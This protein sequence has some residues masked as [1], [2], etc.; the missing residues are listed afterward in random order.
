MA[1]FAGYSFDQRPRL[2]TEEDLE[3][4]STED[5]QVTE[6]TND[7]RTDLDGLLM[8]LEQLE[9]SNFKPNEVV[10]CGN[11][12]YWY[13]VFPFEHFGFIIPSSANGEYLCLDFGRKG[14]VWELFD[15]YPD[16]PEGTFL[17]ER[18]ETDINIGNPWQVIAEYCKDT[19]PFNYFTND[20]KSWSEGL[21][22]VLNLDRV[23]ST[24]TKRASQR[25]VNPIFGRISCV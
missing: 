24:P 16:Y 12:W 4:E 1:Q 6:V 5:V 18:Y 15:D 2:K 23:Q 11:V 19:K 25:G 3:S 22:Q 14:I 8:Y 17:V 10:L 20:C 7:Y 13:G 21:K 9:R